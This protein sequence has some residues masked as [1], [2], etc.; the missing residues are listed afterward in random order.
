MGK[1]KEDYNVWICSDLHLRHKN[2]LK[3]QPLRI[4]GMG[5][6][7]GEDIQGHDEYIINMWNNLVKRGDHVYILGDLIL[8]N[9][10]DSLGILHLLKSKGCVIHLIVGNHDKSTQRMFN[11]FES[12]SLIKNVDFKKSVH[13]FLEEDFQCVM[14]HYPMKSWANKCRGSMNLYGHI[15]NHSPWTD[16][17]D[18]LSMNVGLDNPLC[19]YQLF[20]LEQIYGLY[21]EKLKG[22]KAR[23]YIETVSKENEFFIR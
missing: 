12:I 17:G 9:Q 5:L 6:K 1:E 7:D 10:K 18:D 3:H 11:M 16:D 14:C 15:H 13:P 23:D 22:M 19:N 8:S 20:S 21:K 2:I 4:E